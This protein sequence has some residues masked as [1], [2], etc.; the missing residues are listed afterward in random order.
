VR[1]ALGYAG[2]PL[3]DRR[4]DPAAPAS[5]LAWYSN[6]DGVWPG[7]PRDAFAGAGA[8]H[9]LLLGVPS[10]GLTVVR[11]GGSL[12]PGSWDAGFWSAALRHVFQPVVDAL[13]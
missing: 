11:S 5:G 3:P 12:E 7:I 9:Q 1:Q 13:H 4:A 6:A 8:Q 10:L 2:L